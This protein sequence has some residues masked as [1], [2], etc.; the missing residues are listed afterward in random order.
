MVLRV[1]K[2]RDKRRGMMRA[3]FDSTD[4]SNKH[5]MYMVVKLRVQ[6]RIT[7]VHAGNYYDIYIM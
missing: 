2:T 7:H 5:C 3:A 4:T 1:T 6:N